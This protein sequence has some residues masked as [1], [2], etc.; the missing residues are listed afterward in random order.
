[1]INVTSQYPTQQ[2]LS[3]A[4][5]NIIA[6]VDSNNNTNINRILFP[7]KFRRT[8][9]QTSPDGL[10][11]AMS[12]IDA[13]V[14]SSAYYAYQSIGEAQKHV[15]EVAAYL[16]NEYYIEAPLTGGSYSILTWIS[17]I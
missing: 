3:P 8:V 11:A 17:A 12:Q 13:L 9:A 6:Q 7:K 15:L 1:M 2:F 10:G 14:N 4:A 16:G 5:A